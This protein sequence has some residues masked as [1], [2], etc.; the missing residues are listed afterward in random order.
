MG[1]LFSYNNVYFWLGFFLQAGIFLFFYDYFR[2][3]HK[4]HPS[5]QKLRKEIFHFP[6][7][8][9]AVLSIFTFY[10]IVMA[11]NPTLNTISS[12]F[13]QA[14][15]SS[16]HTISFSIKPTFSLQ[17]KN[18][19]LINVKANTGFLVQ[20][21]LNDATINQIEVRIIQKNQTLYRVCPVKEGRAVLYY[22]DKPTPNEGIEIQILK[23]QNTIEGFNILGI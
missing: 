2:K 13:S 10:G 5:S 15:Y 11:Y 9:L 19:N 22:Q 18:P 21:N 12:T 14:K 7:Y 20:A 8:T 1:F 6:A 17:V 3:I 4:I 16:S 23:P